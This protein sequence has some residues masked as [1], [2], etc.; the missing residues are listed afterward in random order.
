[1]LQH[2]IV[3]SYVPESL[4]IGETCR[5]EG[6]PICVYVGCGVFASIERG[7]HFLRTVIWIIAFGPSVQFLMCCL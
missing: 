3:M 1:M 6:E 7:A 4:G 2:C 5:R